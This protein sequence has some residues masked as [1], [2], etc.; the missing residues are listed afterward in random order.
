MIKIRHDNGKVSLYAHM[1]A[2]LVENGQRV[3]KG[4]VI[5]RVGHTSAKY[6]IGNHLHFELGNS[7]DSGAAGDP[8]QEYFKP[9]YGN[10]VT[11]T[12]AAA[13]YPNP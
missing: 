2:R 6:K 9:K 3:S 4:Q 7:D 11:L 10:I 1:S 13:K 5:G 12:Q 8:W